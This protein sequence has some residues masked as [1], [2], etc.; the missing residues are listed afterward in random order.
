MEIT[1]KNYNLGR[2][3]ILVSSVVY[4]Y[5]KFWYWGNVTSFNVQK[6]IYYNICYR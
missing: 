1:F 5:E 4:N 6:V 2:Y 3:P